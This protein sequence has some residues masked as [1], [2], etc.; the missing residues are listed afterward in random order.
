VNEYQ[1]L[2]A[3]PAEAEIDAAFQYLLL[4]S[5]EAAVR[6]R[7]G[8][9]EAIR[10][11]AQMPQRCSLAP[12]NGLFEH[13]VRQLIYSHGRTRYRI[14]FIVFEPEGSETMGWVRILRVR[15]GAQRHLNRA[16]NDDEDFNQNDE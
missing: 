16:S 14:L 13:T 5:P 11:L 10:S 15:H 4:R 8:V 6:F 7:E 1:I 12:E 9:S 3:E 2:I